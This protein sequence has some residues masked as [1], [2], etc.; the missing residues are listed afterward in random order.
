MATNDVGVIDTFLNTFTTTIDTG[1]GLVKGNLISLAGSLSVLDIALA[2]LFWAWA[3]D[4]DIIQRLVKKTLYIGFFA[5]VINNFDHLS[6]L[7]FDSFARLGLRAGGGTLALADFLRP[8]RLASTGFDAARPLL[9]SAHTLLGPVAFFTNFIQ[10]F[11][12]CLSWLIVL[13]AFFILAVQLFV[14]LI[15]FKLTTLAGF[16][17]IPFALFNRTAF[18]AEKVLGNVVSSG[19]KI[20]VLAVISAIASVLFGQFATSYGSDVPTIGQS[21]SVVLASLAIVGLSI[22]GGSIANGLISG[23]PQLGAG[24]AVGTGM[25]VGAMGAA[26]VAGVGAVASGGAAAVGATAAAARGGA[27]IAGAATSAYSAGAAGASGGA[28]SMAAGIG[29]MGRAVGGNIANAAKGA[30]SRAG[31]S[32]KESYAAGSQWAAQ[33]MGGGQGGETGGSDGGGPTPSGDNPS[34]GG[35]SPAGGGPSGDGDGGGDGGA[36]SGRTA[37]E[38]PRWTRTMK[39]RNAATHAAEAAHVIR[40]A[41]GGGGGGSASID[42]SEKE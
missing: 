41:D 25:A 12:L 2:G 17:L 9:D 42:L 3:A 38:P 21:V 19:V 29:G 14:A 36:G 4:E 33:G 13:A 28:G 40:A 15:E 16:V 26:A 22:F 11:V 39:R 31:S 10:I 8:G 27:A 35:G 20:M 32:L 23:A 5:F 24:A 37:G 7:V 1:F 30:A 34:G 6:K 18:L